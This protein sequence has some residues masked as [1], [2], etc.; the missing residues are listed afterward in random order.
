M[1]IGGGFGGKLSAYLEPVAAVL[2]RKS[3]KPVKMTMSRAEVFESTGPSCGSKVSL[4]L[5]VTKE[6]RITAAKATYLF[7]AGA[8]P[9]APLAAAAAAIFSPYVIDNLLVDAYDIVDNKPKTA[10]YRAPGAPNVVWAVENLMDEIAEVLDIDPMELRMLNVATEGTRRADGGKEPGGRGEGSDG[11]GGGPPPLQR[12]AGGG[13]S[14]ARH[15]HGV[16]PKQHR[17]SVCNCQRTE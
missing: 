11:G 5:G 8:F 14:W 17:S 3:G 9:G 4:K 16:L 15:K 1:E 6:G 2:S 12:A 13:E 10:A 7:E